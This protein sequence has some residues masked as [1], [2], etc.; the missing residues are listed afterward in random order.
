MRIRR[1]AWP[2]RA[3]RLTALAD[4]IAGNIQMVFDSFAGIIGAERGGQVR[5]IGLQP[6]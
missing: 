5:A 3:I 4:L 2:N 1:R 6:E